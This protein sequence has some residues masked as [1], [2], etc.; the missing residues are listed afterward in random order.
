MSHWGQ[1]TEV[2]LSD[3]VLPLLCCS[4]FLRQRDLFQNLDNLRVIRVLVH[5]HSEPSLPVQ[6]RARF[7]RAVDEVFGDIYTAAFV[8]Y[9]EHKTILTAPSHGFRADD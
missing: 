4:A 3:D 7:R 8:E 9:L 5:L 6:L 2:L 1:V